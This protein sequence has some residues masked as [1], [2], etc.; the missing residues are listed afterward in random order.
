MSSGLR[1]RSIVGWGSVALILA[2]FFM[3]V[4][5]DETDPGVAVNDV[6]T[7]SPP[8]PASDAASM[9]H[10]KTGGLGTTTA[11]TNA[12]D[13]SQQLSGA[14]AGSNADNM[15]LTKP[16]PPQGL[17]APKA[18]I[19]IGTIAA[20]PQDKLGIV[21]QAPQ[22]IPADAQTQ[23]PALQQPGLSDV[24]VASDAALQANADVSVRPQTIRPMALIPDS[25]RDIVAA[26][27]ASPEANTA[28]LTLQDRTVEVG[29]EGDA[30]PTLPALTVALN[31]PVE[32]FVLLDTSRPAPVAIGP[33]PTGLTFSATGG[34]ATLASPLSAEGAVNP[35]AALAEQAPQLRQADGTAETTLVVPSQPARSAPVVLQLET[36]KRPTALTA[37]A[38]SPTVLALLGSRRAGTGLSPKQPKLKPDIPD[39]A[40]AVAS[41]VAKSS[42]SAKPQGSKMFVTGG[43]VNLRAAPGVSHE[44]VGQFSRGTELAAFETVGNWMRVESVKAG[45]R[46]AGWMSRRYLAS[47]LPARA[48]A[49]PK[50]TNLR[51][52]TRS[53]T[54]AASA[55][56]ANSSRRRDATR[57][58]VRRA[59]ARIIRQ[60]IAKFGGSCTCPY[61]RDPSGNTC[62][63]RSEWSSPRGYSPICYASDISRRHLTGYLAQRGLSFRQ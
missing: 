39:L 42:T 26:L 20:V 31:A 33:S 59:E 17:D 37:P 38:T 48:K 40:P 6:S 8:L 18:P 30:K 35:E 51:A 25:S 50:A 9:A 44:I 29:A 7:F 32:E 2:L 60:S 27:T 55:P 63:D 54:K 15:L 24:A 49:A 10:E 23:S 47:T 3:P 43:R 34:P 16:T 14:P 45:A 13:L 5:L 53:V 4:Q 58:E 52:K 57:A 41:S 28:S 36:P 56:R 21:V 11:L 62:G 19:P 22:A 46:Q 61:H 12:P 1:L